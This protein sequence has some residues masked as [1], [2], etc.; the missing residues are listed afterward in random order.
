MP[1]T[2]GASAAYGSCIRPI[3]NAENTASLGQPLHHGEEGRRVVGGAVGDAHAQ[4]DQRRRV[5]Q[6]VADQLVDEHQMAGVEHL[7]LRL[8]PKARTCSAMARNIAGV[9]VIT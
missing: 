1:P 9:F 3:E 7:E 5:D 8:D 4:L 2:I 6:P